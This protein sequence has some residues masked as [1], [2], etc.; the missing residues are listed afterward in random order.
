MHFST[1]CIKVLFIPALPDQHIPS[2]H[3]IRGASRIL[4]AC[5]IERTTL[6]AV[7]AVTREHYLG[8]LSRLSSNLESFK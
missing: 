6:D 7:R 5:P 2:L 3:F 8:G 1:G 4:R